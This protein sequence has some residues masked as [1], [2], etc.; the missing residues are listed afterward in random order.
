MIHSFSP[1]TAEGGERQAREERNG[2]RG[3]TN[4]MSYGKTGRQ[5]LSENAAVRC[6][7]N[8]KGGPYRGSRDTEGLETWLSMETIKDLL[9]DHFH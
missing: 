6:I 5:D 1:N 3:R 7:I 4:E 8:P 9:K 2:Y